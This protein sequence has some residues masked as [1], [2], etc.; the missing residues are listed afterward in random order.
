LFEPKARI[1]GAD[2]AEC[3]V[4][5]IFPIGST[6]NHAQL[7]GFVQY[8]VGAQ[9]TL[10]DHSQHPMELV[11]REYARRRIV[12]RWRKCLECNVDDNTKRKG[13]VL[14]HRAFRP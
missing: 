1:S 14:V 9:L 8:F 12:D 10:A 13:G 5:K 3:E 11:N 2:L 4:H 6:E 7:P